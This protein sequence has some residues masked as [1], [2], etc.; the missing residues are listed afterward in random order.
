[1]IN[2]Y[3]AEDIRRLEEPYVTAETY[4][5]SLMRKAAYGLYKH[6]AK[7]HE[8]RADSR[9]LVLVGSGNNGGD[10]LYAAT[11]LLADGFAVDA[12]LLGS[13]AHTEGL[14]AYKDAGG[15][16]IDPDSLDPSAYGLII[17]A[18]LGTGARGGLR[19]EAA[20]VVNRLRTETDRDILVI[21]CDV[22]SGVDGNTGAVHQPVLPADVTVTFIARKVPHLSAAEHLCGR[23]E[24][25]ELGIEEDLAKYEPAVSRL[26]I[27]ELRQAMVVPGPYDHKYTRGVCGI[28]TGSEEYP[29]AALLS[30]QA[31]VNTGVGMVRFGVVGQLASMI[32]LRTPE[33]VCFTSSPEE[34]HVQAW[35]AGSGATGEARERDIDVALA[36]S[37]PAIL[38]AAAVARTAQWV[39]DNGVLEANN[40]LTPHA[41]E[42]EEFL[43]WM[44]ALSYS[45]WHRV[46]GDEKA[47]TRAEIE[48]DPLRWAKVASSLSGATVLLK[49]AVTH[50]ASPDGKVLS[51]RSDAHYLAT[52]GSGDVLSGILGGLI[53]QNEAQTK[54]APT[55]HV[56]ALAS[57]IHSNSALLNNGGKGPTPASAIVDNIPTAIAHLLG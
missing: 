8:Q 15:N 12:V 7:L 5:G 28:L 56:A 42:L 13:R 55:A 50:I 31:C 22:P 16:L 36:A 29:G 44:S 49:D 24:V 46:V 17:D 34:Q 33:V 14:E 11:H 53:A 38:D 20:T 40:I 21:A 1:M 35:L 2:A 27:H 54:P 37:E 10:G 45:T 9:I 39:S 4:D 47:P 57:V 25:V 51:V 48:N 26:E 32:N 23:V 52:A 41:G 6:A 18:I 19:D 30:T 3:T 43:V